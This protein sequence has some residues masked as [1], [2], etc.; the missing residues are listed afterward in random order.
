MMTRDPIH[1][2]KQV[3]LFSYAN[4]TIA[5]MTFDELKPKSEQMIQV[6]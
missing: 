5:N 1:F 6:R 4:D 2:L 3:G